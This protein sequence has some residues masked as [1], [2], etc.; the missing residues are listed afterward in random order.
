MGCSPDY[1]ISTVRLGQSWPFVPVCLDSLM[2]GRAAPIVICVLFPDPSNHC[3]SMDMEN[4]VIKLIYC[5]FVLGLSIHL[6]MLYVSTAHTP[7]LIF[8]SL[9]N[10][11]RGSSSRPG[12]SAQDRINESP[13]CFVRSKNRSSILHGS[14][15]AQVVTNN[16]THIVPNTIIGSPHSFANIATD[17]IRIRLP[18]P[19]TP[20]VCPCRKHRIRIRI[21]S[22]R[23]WV[24]LGKQKCVC[25]PVSRPFSLAGLFF[26]SRYTSCEISHSSGKQN[27]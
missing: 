24:L 6:L 15:S 20:K 16:A 13:S 14:K 26:I 10:P 1:I 27:T 7:H 2:Q 22:R 11:L 9:S 21:L 25:M 17:L 23:R 3:L 12:E 4:G 18:V 5:V 8:I 19:N